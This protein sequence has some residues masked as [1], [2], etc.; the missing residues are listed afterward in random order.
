MVTVNITSQRTLDTPDDIAAFLSESYESAD[1]AAFKPGDLVNVARA[2]LPPEM[3]VGDVA[4]VL[5]DDP[6]PSPYTTVRM[7]HASG[8][9]MTFQAQTTNLTKRDGA[10]S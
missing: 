3:G 2:G 9:L 7:L 6:K 1:G 8:A 4:I 10:A 5:Y